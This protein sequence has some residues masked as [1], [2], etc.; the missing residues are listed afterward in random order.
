MA[1]D[2]ATVFQKTPKKIDGTNTDWSSI[3]AGGE[4]TCGLKSDALW[5]WGYNANGQLGDATTV[6]KNASA[7]VRTAVAVRT[8]CL[9]G[10]YNPN[11]GSTSSSACVNA[12]AGYYVFTTGQSSQTACGAGTYNPN[13]GS[14]SSSACEDCQSGTYQASTGKSSC[15]NASAGYF[16]PTTAAIAQTVCG[17]GTEQPFTGQSSCSVTQATGLAQ[18]TCT[19]LKNEYQRST[20]SDKCEC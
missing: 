4:H 5:C 15:V 9:A 18:A 20:R 10:T 17:P 7:I 14:T 19:Q 8:A 16:V 3:T 13:T 12:D 6:Q 11:T 1:L 2:S